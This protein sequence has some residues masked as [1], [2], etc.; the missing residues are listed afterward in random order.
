LKYEDRPDYTTLKYL[1]YNLLIPDD[2]IYNEFVFDWFDENEDNKKDDEAIA[3]NSAF[4]FKK[5]SN[6]QNLV[7][8]KIFNF[9]FFRKE[10]QTYST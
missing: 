6:N 4:D 10:N 2:N 8:I 7:T 9:I 5:T 3:A 1:F